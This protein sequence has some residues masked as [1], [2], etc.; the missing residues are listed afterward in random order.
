MSRVGARQLGPR[1]CADAHA[2]ALA[3][4]LDTASRMHR[5]GTMHA[6]AA[7]LQAAIE[8]N[9]AVAAPSLVREALLDGQGARPVLRVPVGLPESHAQ[10]TPG[11]TTLQCTLPDPPLVAHWVLNRMAPPWAEEVLAAAA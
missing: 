9:A 10:P 5:A 3:A 7:V 1:T 2:H 8:E 6:E 11:V 4:V